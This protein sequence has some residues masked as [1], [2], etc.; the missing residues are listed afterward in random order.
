MLCPIKTCAVSSKN[1][2]SLI[3]KGG[4]KQSTS[5]NK[6]SLSVLFMYGSW[7]LSLLDCKTLPSSSSSSSSLLLEEE[8]VSF[9][10]KS[11]SQ[12]ISSI[13]AYEIP[14]CLAASLSIEESQI[15]S[16]KVDQDDD[17]M[18][19]CISDIINTTNTSDTT[20][21]L[22]GD[23][24]AIMQSKDDEKVKQTQEEE[25]EFQHILQ[26]PANLPAL[27]IIARN[28][29]Q[30]IHVSNVNFDHM[31]LIHCLKHD[32]Q[33]PY[34]HD[35]LEVMVANISSSIRKVSPSSSSSSSSSNNNNNNNNNHHNNLEPQNSTSSV[36]NI[37]N[38]N[39]ISSS[40]NNQL[41]VPNKK[42]IRIFIAGDRSQVGKSSV[43]L[44]IIGTLI[45]KL[46]YN[47]SQL[48]YIKPATQCEE[49]QLIAKYCDEHQITN[50]PIGPIVYY[51]GFTRAFLKGQT[52]DTTASLLQQV[53]Q[54]VNEISQNKDVVII[55]GVGYPAVGSICGTDNVSVANACSYENTTVPPAV[56]IVGKRG[57]GDAID[58]YNLNATYFRARDIKV[59]GAV[60]N[61]LPNDPN[62]FYSLQNCKDAIHSYFDGPK[63][64]SI[65]NEELVFGFI[66]EVEGLASSSV[67]ESANKFI[68]IFSEHV[69]LAR[70]LDRA[71]VLRDNGYEEDSITISTTTS[72]SDQ[73]TANNNEGFH[74]K[75]RKLSSFSSNNS[76]RLTRDDIER[77]ATIEGAAGG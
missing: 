48:A 60:F 50:R 42:Q 2:I 76:I 28:G 7:N 6:I 59:M 55:D 66:P 52:N 24:D 64:S 61:R 14:S 20:T 30:D 54:A 63:S 32:K 15:L 25:V 72:F 13:L 73:N 46:N 71:Q 41:N 1:V 53:R 29:C 40:S 38:H 47:P 74:V 67:V 23:N 65:A 58:S 45:K 19:L 35:F 9:H 10:R 75:K 62:H 3:T 17:T 8:I 39:N 12:W 51:K 22:D 18:N 37:H 49:S 11:L 69:D 5:V 70:L 21:F 4:D 16:L 36:I 68:D 57:V 44:G 26:A 27:V 33:S 77:A 43:C 31:H 34:Y 56:L